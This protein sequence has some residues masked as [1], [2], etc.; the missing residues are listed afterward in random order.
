MIEKMKT[1][2][3]FAKRPSHWHHALE[4]AKRK[5]MPD[6]DTPDLRLKAT[7]WAAG[8]AVS[9]N[10]AL[11]SVGID[12]EVIN[13]GSELL[14]SAITLA[15]ASPKVMGGPADLDLI[16]NAAHLTGARLCIE[17]GVA[18]GWS[19]LAILDA[20]KNT[21]GGQL[22]SID[23]HYPKKDNEQF[24]GIV[25]PPMLRENWDL[26]RQ[27]DRNGIKKALNNIGG[28]IDFCHYDS[29]KSWWGRAY[30][31]PILWDALK[32]G[33][34]FISDDIQDNL[35]FRKFA[36]SKGNPFAV[37]KSNGKFIG[38]IRK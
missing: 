14:E 38:I 36:K 7:E 15:K 11:K 16:W 34:I 1:S 6:F 29:D 3:W 27:P 21:K 10:A 5:F 8:Q 23:M 33:G 28:K 9:I 26:I 4:L 20:I 30:A 22:C 2:I 17:T 24:V 35:F 18:Y 37:T 32:P 12:G 31:F 25:V 13:V 19:S